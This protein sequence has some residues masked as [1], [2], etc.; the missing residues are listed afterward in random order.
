ME[1]TQEMTQEAEQKLRAEV[2]A[3]LDAEEKG[4]VVQK[5]SV[6][7]SQKETEK[8]EVVDPWAGVNPALKQMFDDMSQKVAALPTV[9]ARLKQAESR[10]GSLSNELHNAKQAA[11]AVKDAPTKEQMEAAAKSEEG[12]QALKEDFPEWAEAI[13]GRVNAKLA[14]LKEEI[15]AGLH[16]E[17]KTAEEIAQ[18]KE[19]LAEGTAEQIQMGIL[20]FLKPGYQSTVAMKEYQ[21]WLKTQPE[22]IVK[23]TKSPRA[24]DAIVVLDSFEESV[25]KQKTAEE[26]A[27]E[28]KRRLKTAHIPQGKK[29]APTKSEADMTEAEL[30]QSLAKEVW[31]S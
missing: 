3:E 17:G 24:A 15:V 22:D 25:G 9:E 12:W 18:L 1:A 30:R 5:P 27:S 21:E 6:D 2:A 13:D 20:E 11:A 8:E 29:S 19:T 10:V 23:L 28:R 14:T 16:G 7:V 26:I 4:E 31:A